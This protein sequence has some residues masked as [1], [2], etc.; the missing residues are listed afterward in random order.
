MTVQ[1]EGKGL[2]FSRLR[3]SL[4][5]GLSPK[6][7]AI[8]RRINTKR[9]SVFIIKLSLQPITHQGIN[10]LRPPQPPELKGGA[11]YASVASIY[12]IGISKGGARK[13]VGW[14]L[15]RSLSAQEFKPYS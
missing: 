7:K 8:I 10:S 6:I 11:R 12:E 9:I 2:L 14:A 15:P 5:K 1:R 13:V 4:V 3:L